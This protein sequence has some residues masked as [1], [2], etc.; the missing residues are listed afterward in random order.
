MSFLV[1]KK[2][3]G[4][5]ERWMYLPSL[6]LVKRLAASDKRTSFVG[7]TFF[8][9]DISGR[10]VHEDDHK[11]VKTT[12]DFYI[13]DNFPKDKSVEFKKY[14]AWIHKQTFLPIKIEYYGADDKAYRRY[15]VL[16]VSKVDGLV[17][18]LA[19]KMEDLKSKSYTINTFSKVQYNQKFEDSIFTERYLRKAPQNLLKW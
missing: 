8:Y 14:T 17:T 16:K 12:K 1:W 4:D 13:I 10:G 3:K 11:L 6:D 7:S 15:S 2:V 19:S 5:D 9:E 18:V